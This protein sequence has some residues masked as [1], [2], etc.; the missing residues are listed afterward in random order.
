RIA[1]AVD[2]SAEQ[3]L[4]QV[5]NRISQFELNCALRMNGWF[6]HHL[7]KEI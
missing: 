2:I 6:W 3:Q 5:R 7:D 1:P 4:T